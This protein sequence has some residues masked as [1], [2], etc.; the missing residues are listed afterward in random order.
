MLR[1]AKALTQHLGTK[2]HDIDVMLIHVHKSALESCHGFLTQVWPGQRLKI[3]L[4]L[5]V[6]AMQA[7]T[8]VE[9]ILLGASKVP[10]HV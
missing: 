8:A 7:A 9:L 4:W 5:K 6:M 2:H 10:S 3:Y 1:R